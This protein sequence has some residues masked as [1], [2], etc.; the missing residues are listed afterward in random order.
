MVMQVVTGPV[1]LA[2]VVIFNSG[3]LAQCWYGAGSDCCGAL[4]TVVD[5]APVTFAKLTVELQKLVV[6]FVPMPVPCV[7][8]SCT[9]TGNDAS[10]KLASAFVPRTET[11]VVPIPKKVPVGGLT[12]TVPQLP[13]NE[14]AGL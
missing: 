3:Q 9:V 13:V 8:F 5:P 14:I 12:T 1:K 4:V 6:T 2:V 10:V 11:V 7:S